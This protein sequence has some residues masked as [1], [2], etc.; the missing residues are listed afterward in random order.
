MNNPS[1]ARLL[2]KVDS[3]LS[4]GLDYLQREAALLICFYFSFKF[5]L[6]QSKLR[7]LS[8]APFSVTPAS[9]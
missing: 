4:F 2:T 3:I 5:L 1:L 7:I 6:P 9:R 8:G